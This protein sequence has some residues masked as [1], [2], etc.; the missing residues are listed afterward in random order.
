MR[1]LTTSKPKEVLGV[2]PE[3]QSR[4][5][6]AG[7]RRTLATRAVLGLF[8]ARPAGGLTHAQALASLTA[9]GLDINRVTL[10]RLLDR[11]AGCGVLQ[12]QAD[13]ART[14]RFSLALPEPAAVEE[15]ALPRFECDACHRQFRLTDASEPTRAVTHDLFAA[16][17]RLGHHGDRVDVSIHGTCAGCAEPVA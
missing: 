13:D 12:R 11:L 1:S 9:R 2:P 10:Y 5:E 17:A 4:L 8:L 15:G 7:L 3:I 6:K 16:L 14:W